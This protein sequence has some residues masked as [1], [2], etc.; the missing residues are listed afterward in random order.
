M[1]IPKQIKVLGHIYKIKEVN[2]DNKF[3]DVAYSRVDRLKQEIVIRDTL[4]RSFKEECLLHELLHA[5]DHHDA[6]PEECIQNLSCNL[7]Q[8]LK[9][10]KLRF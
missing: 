3:L 5:C 9:D 2:P 7:Y 8:V 1:K 4:S 10:N 6:I